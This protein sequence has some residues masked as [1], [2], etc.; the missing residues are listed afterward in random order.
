MAGPAP[1]SRDASASATR[2]LSTV[3]PRSVALEGL[4]IEAGPRATMGTN[5]ERT[6]S[7]VSPIAWA[8]SHRAPNGVLS[9]LETATV[10]DRPR[11]RSRSKATWSH[12][13]PQRRTLRLSQLHTA[14]VARSPGSFWLLLRYLE[15]Q[16]PGGLSR[17]GRERSARP[18]LYGPA[19]PFARRGD[20]S[21]VGTGDNYRRVSMV[22][23]VCPEIAARVPETRTHTHRDWGRLTNTDR[24]GRHAYIHIYPFRK[25]RTPIFQ[26]GRLRREFELDEHTVIPRHRSRR[27]GLLSASFGR[28]R[29]LE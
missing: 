9:R 7:A 2:R 24:A 18:E 10:S 11:S 1:R 15:G 13:K 14:T 4:A 5:K 28:S 20:S 3:P 22:R 12:Y 16:R 8:L 29:L 21:R 26:W 27:R 6:T 25:R 23:A 19:G 17:E